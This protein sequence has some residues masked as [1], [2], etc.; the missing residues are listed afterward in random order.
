M[1]AVIPL[2]TYFELFLFTLHFCVNFTSYLSC[3]NVQVY[4]DCF[5][6]VK[7][8]LIQGLCPVTGPFIFRLT[9]SSSVCSGHIALQEVHAFVLGHKVAF[10]LSG[11]V[12]LYSL[13]NTT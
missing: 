4:C 12:L 3:N 2:L 1:V 9:W 5:L 10:C 13:D 6:F 11:T 8:F 7:W